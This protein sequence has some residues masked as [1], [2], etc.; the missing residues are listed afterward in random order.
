[1]TIGNNV[2]LWGHHY[3]LTND[4]VIGNDTVLANATVVSYFNISAIAKISMTVYRGNITTMLKYFATT[5]DPNL[6]P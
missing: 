3:V 6:I 5:E 1:M 2:H 4:N